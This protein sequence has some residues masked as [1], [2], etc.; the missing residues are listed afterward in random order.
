[1]FQ[2]YKY[3][4]WIGFF[5]RYSLKIA[6]LSANKFSQSANARFVC[7]RRRSYEVTSFEKE[8]FIA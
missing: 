4:Q 8:Q 3:M 5:L 1:M 6:T 7:T 2:K